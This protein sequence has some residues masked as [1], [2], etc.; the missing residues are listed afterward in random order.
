MQCVTRTATEPE[1]ARHTLTQTHAHMYTHTQS[2]THLCSHMQ[3]PSH[4]HHQTH[5]HTSV[6]QN[7]CLLTFIYS[8]M[9]EY[10]AQ[11]ENSES[12]ITVRMGGV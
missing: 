11:P 4:A 8:D 10:K 3:T 7:D 9:L 1:D 2:H 5:T 12:H 6:I